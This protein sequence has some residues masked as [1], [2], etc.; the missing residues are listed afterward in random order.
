MRFLTPLFASVLLALGAGCATDYQLGTTL[1]PDLRDVYVPSVQNQ[2]Q[3]PTIHQDATRALLREIRRDGT[4]NLITDETSA[5]TILEVTILKFNMSAL[6]YQR[7]DKHAGRDYRGTVTAH[8]VFRKRATG[9]VL[10]EGDI[11]GEEEFDA[12]GDLTSAKRRMMPE[13]CKDL[14]ERIVDACISIW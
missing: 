8:V 11:S 4:L 6:T 3:E 1:A 12:T 5:S 9:T 10:Y 7:N 14:A 2:S 13:A